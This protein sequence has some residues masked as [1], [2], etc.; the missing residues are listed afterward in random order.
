MLDRFVHMVKS[1]GRPEEGVAQAKEEARDGTKNRLDVLIS[2]YQARYQKEIAMSLLVVIFLAG[3]LLANWWVQRP[4]KEPIVIESSSEILSSENEDSKNGLSDMVTVDVAG[5]VQKPGVYELEE[6]SRLK[7]LIEKAGGLTEEVDQGYLEK[8][9]NLAQILSDGVKIYLPR[10][11]D[12]DSDTISSWSNEL[13]N[14][15]SGGVVGGTVVQGEK[16]NINTASLTELQ[17]LSGIGPKT[18]QKIVAGRPYKKIED[19]LK[20]SGIGPKTFA[21]IKDMITVQ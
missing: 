15:A 16:I 3:L 2:L 21:K 9:I 5:A 4:S 7:D 20:V 8:N 6:G 14:Q 13:E 18:A 1:L 10:K 17:V 19:I 11:S 12:N